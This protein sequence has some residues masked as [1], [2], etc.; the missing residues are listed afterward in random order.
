MNEFKRATEDEQLYRAAS[1]NFAYNANYN[2]ATGE[3]KLAIELATGE[4]LRNAKG[5]IL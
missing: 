1:F 2:Y 4:S 3:L 5:Y